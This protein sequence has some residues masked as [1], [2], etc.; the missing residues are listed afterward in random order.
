MKNHLLRSRQSSS[1]LTLASTSRIETGITEAVVAADL[2]DWHAGF[3]LPQKANDLLF[4]EPACPH[5][6]HCPKLM[7]FLEK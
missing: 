5:V 4:A 3:D 1:T 7:D 2:L 6:Q